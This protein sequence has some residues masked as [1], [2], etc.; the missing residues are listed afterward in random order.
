MI[1]DGGDFI[2]REARPAEK[3]AIQLRIAAEIFAEAMAW[4]GY[5]AANVGEGD[6]VFGDVFLRET[7]A[8]YLLPVVSASVVSG[9]ERVFPEIRVATVAGVRIGIAGVLHGGF[10]A[11]VQAHSDPG[12]PLRVV[13]AR[14]AAARA[15]QLLEPESV[16]VKILLA[17]LPADDLRA[18]VS[19]VPGF[20]IA[21]PAHDASMPAL[22]AGD[23]VNGTV[24]A[25]SLG[26]DGQLIGRLNLLVHLDTP[27]VEVTGSETIPLDGTWP[28]HPEMVALHDRYLERVKEAVD[29]ILEAYPVSPPPSGGSYVGSLACRTCHQ[30]SWMSWRTREHAAAWQTLRDLQRDYDPECFACHSTGF[31]Y[32]GG[33]RIFDDTPQMAGV[34]CESCHGAGQEHCDAPDIPYGATSEATCR[35]C[36]VEL[37]SPDFDYATYLP[38]VGCLQK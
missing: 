4:L 20:D 25:P 7:A 18:L 13:D 14:D 23:D 8:R 31:Q 10:D 24:V 32:T 5:G 1:V 21:I 6:L 3:S 26:W 15:L 29:E 16:R 9:S 38:Q 35:S 11:Y 19:E 28:D 17:H 2:A 22:P 33:F 37:H 30:T 12:R 36:H 34:Q 27:L